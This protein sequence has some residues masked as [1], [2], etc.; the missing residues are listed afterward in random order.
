MTA[1]APLRTASRDRAGHPAVLERA[2]RVRALE[3]E[4]HLDAGALGDAL[5]E[6]ERRRALLQRDDRVARGERQPLA[7]TRDQA[8]QLLELLV[9]APGSR[10]ARERTN[11]IRE[12]S[13]TAP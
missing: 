1:S 4:P 8:H 9:D 6:H 13:C 11:A 3:L 2:G 5:G 7:V 10:A 12:T